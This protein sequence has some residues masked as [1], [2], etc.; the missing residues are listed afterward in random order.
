MPLRISLVKMY[1]LAMFK[2]VITYILIAV[3]SLMIFAGCS[4][5]DNDQDKPFNAKEF[6]DELF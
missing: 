3:M 1:N 6:V 2:R 5:A 4:S